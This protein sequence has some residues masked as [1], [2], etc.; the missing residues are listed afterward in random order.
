MT[1]AQTRLKLSQCQYTHQ[2]IQRQIRVRV[3]MQWRCIFHSVIDVIVPYLRMIFR[4]YHLLFE[5]YQ[6]KLYLGV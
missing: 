4:L 6:R 3:Q 1:D 5:H 2:V